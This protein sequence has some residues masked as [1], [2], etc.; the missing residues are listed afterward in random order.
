MALFLW[1]ILTNT[2]T[3]TP[4][5]AKEETQLACTKLLGMWSS[6]QKQN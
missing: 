1:R 6:G 4:I 2:N 5:K 3:P